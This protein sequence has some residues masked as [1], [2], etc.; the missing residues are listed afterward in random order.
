M[1]EPNGDRVEPDNDQ[2]PDELK[3]TCEGMAD[4]PGPI[5]GDDQE[6]GSER[7]H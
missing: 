1:T 4:I 2:V 5:E 7:T 6:D 3:P